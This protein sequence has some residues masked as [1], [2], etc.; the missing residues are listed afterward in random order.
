MYVTGV[1][2]DPMFDPLKQNE[3]DTPNDEDDIYAVKDATT[4]TFWI[5]FIPVAAVTIFMVIV[6]I[7]VFCCMEPRRGH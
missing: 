4:A 7:I 1:S 3:F 5:V 6:V 2:F